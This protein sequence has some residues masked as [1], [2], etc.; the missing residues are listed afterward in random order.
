M[1]TV[2]AAIDTTACAG[3][4]LDTAA[5]VAALFDATPRALHVREDASDAPRR[6]AR[7]AAIELRETTGQPVAAI[8]AAATTPDVVALVLGAR[9]VHGGP[10][11]AG[12][13]ALDVITRVAKPV[14]VVPPHVQPPVRVHAHP[15]ATRRHQRE[16]RGARRD[17]RA[18]G[19]RRPRDRR[20]ARPLARHRCRRSPIRLTTRRRHGSA[21]SSP[22]SSHA[23]HEGARLIRRLGVAADDVVAVARDADADLIALAW[24]QDLGPGHARVV[25]ETLARSTIPVLLVPVH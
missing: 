1:T 5:Q 18:R 12:S 24:S 13:T 9:G 21:S 2:L 7:A 14:V 8:V 20:A 11:P 15:G 22:A 10:Q 25:R 19:P 3:P 4:V 23:A 17:H 6:L 16:L